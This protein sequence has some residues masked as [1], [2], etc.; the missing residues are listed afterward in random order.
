MEGRGSTA[1]ASRKQPPRRC[2]AGSIAGLLALAA[3]AA[4]L[5]TGRMQ[6]GHACA[7]SQ[8]AVRLLSTLPS[9]TATGGTANQ[10]LSKAPTPVARGRTLVL[11]T[12]G[13]PDPGEVVTHSLP[14]AFHQC[15]RA[16][17]WRSPHAWQLWQRA[18]PPTCCC[19]P[20]APPELLRSACQS[21]SCVQST[22]RTSVSL[23]KRQSGQVGHQPLSSMVDVLP[24][25]LIP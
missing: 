4:V 1:A 12:Y 22:L 23:C 25:S 15:S 19:L 11:Y 7:I 5:I 6:A 8:S 21:P 16:R 14:M 17:C 24:Q 20:R 13:G 2:R 18:S 9:G 3:L 10:T